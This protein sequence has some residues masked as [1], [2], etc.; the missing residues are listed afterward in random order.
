MTYD[1]PKHCAAQSKSFLRYIT[2]RK[3]YP[4]H[5]IRCTRE[6]LPG[7]RRRVYLWGLRCTEG[8]SDRVVGERR[9]GHRLYRV[10]SLQHRIES[11][12]QRVSRRNLQEGFPVT[13]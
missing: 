12:H 7:A 8:R 4:T 1:F 5:R 9:S 2:L 6:G 11:L 13:A 3:I 10:H